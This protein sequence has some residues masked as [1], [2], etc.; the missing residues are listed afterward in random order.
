MT[1]KS[2]FTSVIPV[3]RRRV[4][5]LRVLLP[6]LRREVLVPV[7]LV[8]LHEYDDVALAVAARRA[9]HHL[10]QDEL[11]EEGLELLL[12]AVVAQLV[13]QAAKVVAA[14]GGG[15]ERDQHVV[16][17]LAKL[18]DGDVR[19]AVEGARVV[20][21]QDGAEHGGG[22]A[23]RHFELAPGKRKGLK[24]ALQMQCAEGMS[25]FRIPI[26]KKCRLP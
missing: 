12:R 6:H 1:G 25:H 26:W 8:L 24:H 13:Q 7:D 19:R 23:L 15:G 17:G 21:A 20:E 14:D 16:G 4:D 22:E 10:R 9:H 3:K 11:L 5:G 2:P 18:G